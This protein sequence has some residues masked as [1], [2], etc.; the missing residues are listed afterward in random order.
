MQQTTANPQKELTGAG[1]YTRCVPQIRQHTDNVDHRLRQ[2]NDTGRCS[3]QSSDGFRTAVENMPEE[4]DLERAAEMPPGR[5]DA[6]SSAIAG[7][8]SN[9]E[10]ENNQNYHQDRDDDELNVKERSEEDS[11]ENLRTQDCDWGTNGGDGKADWERINAEDQEF[12]NDHDTHIQYADHGDEDAAG[13]SSNH[14]TTMRER[15]TL[16]EA[17][18]CQN[19]EDEHEAIEQQRRLSQRS[20]EEA[21]RRK[22]HRDAATVPEGSTG[23]CKALTTEAEMHQPK[24]AHVNRSR[25][26]LQGR[27]GSL[28]G[29]STGRLRAVRPERHQ[30]QIISS[31]APRLHPDHSWPDD[32]DIGDPPRL[33]N[34]A[35]NRTSQPGQQ[36]SHFLR[37]QQGQGP[38]H[39]QQGQEDDSE[40]RN[41]TRESQRVFNRWQAGQSEAWEAEHGAAQRAE[42]ADESLIEVQT[43]GTDALQNDRA[44]TSRRGAGPSGDQGVVIKVESESEAEVGQVVQDRSGH[45]RR[46]PQRATQTR[47]REKSS[48]SSDTSSSSTT[49]SRSREGGRNTVRQRRR[50]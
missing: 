42:T 20:A 46:V 38:G 18:F 36:H 41:A 4:R 50:R 21:A 32:S 10:V 39:P 2:P 14:K 5:I 44:A 27:A 49:S 34:Q 8:D 9:D 12:R 24:P 33:P 7:D 19:T 25:G 3:E 30:R 22:K 17:D 40:T 26:I 16:E 23:G 28:S 1:K 47:Q 11:D 13:P 6:P 48:S 31:P 29:P 15:R 37:R 45:R 35:R 43:D